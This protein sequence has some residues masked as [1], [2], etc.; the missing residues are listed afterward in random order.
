MSSNSSPPS[1]SSITRYNLSRV[2]MTSNSD[3]MCKCFSENKITVSRRSFSKALVGSVCSCSLVRSMTFTAN[4]SVGLALRM[5]LY[6]VALAPAPT[7]LIIAYGFSCGPNVWYVPS[8]NWLLTCSSS[9]QAAAARWS[10]AP[11]AAAWEPGAAA[12]ACAAPAAGAAAARASER[13]S[14]SFFRRL[15]SSGFRLSLSPKSS[16][17]S[18]ISATSAA[19]LLLH[20]L[21]AS[22]AYCSSFKRSSHSARPR[23]GSS[24]AADAC[25]F[26]S[27]N[28]SPAH[29]ASSAAPPTTP[30]ASSGGPAIGPRRRSTLQQTSR[31]A[32]SSEAAP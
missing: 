30:A 24:R 17:L 26:R 9:P 19:P 8:K 16:Q 15:L 1:T 11:G 32:S 5:H 21:D 13:F 18:K 3:T 27:L 28:L 20:H 12:A 4:G 6:T 23:T 2:S 29:C 31:A 22:S 25:F 7:S 14:A 10:G